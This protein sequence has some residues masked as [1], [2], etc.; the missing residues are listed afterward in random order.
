MA[1]E[2]GHYG[3]TLDSRDILVAPTQEEV[4]LDQAV[5]NLHARGIYQRGRV[6]DAYHD[7]L[8]QEMTRLRGSPI[9]GPNREYP[10]TGV[11]ILV[12]ISAALWGLSKIKL[13][14]PRRTRDWGTGIDLPA[15][16]VVKQ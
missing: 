13:Q 9:P 14:V 8:T 11:A 5:A 3:A 2:R 12:G 4:L 16:R 10:G 1:N 15:M 6:D 7:Q